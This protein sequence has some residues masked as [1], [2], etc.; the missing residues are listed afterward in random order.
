MGGIKHQKWVVYGI[1]IPTLSS[2]SWCFPPI[3][4]WAGRL[5]PLAVLL[6]RKPVVLLSRAAVGSLETGQRRQTL[7]QPGPPGLI[8]DAF[9]SYIL[10]F[11]N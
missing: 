6:K 8:V 4:F 7:G 9:I 10:A 1:A 11:G 2:L 5:P 3:V